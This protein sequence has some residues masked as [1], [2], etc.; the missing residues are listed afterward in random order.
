MLSW[1]TARE[2]CCLL[3]ISTLMSTTTPVI[4]THGENRQKI[5]GLNFSC[6]QLYLYGSFPLRKGKLDCCRQLIDINVDIQRTQLFSPAVYRLNINTGKSPTV[7]AIACSQEQLSDR[8]NYYQNQ[9]K[10]W[11]KVRFRNVWPTWRES[12]KQAKLRLHG[13]FACWQDY[14]LVVGW[15]LRDWH[16]IPS[17]WRTPFRKFTVICACLIYNNSRALCGLLQ[18]S[19][20]NDLVCGMHGS[21]TICCRLLIVVD[22]V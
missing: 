17:Q 20:T 10:K 22:Y 6:R 21:A 14:C 7:I 13:K 4:F 1:Y 3:W 12:V 8:K 5:S 9:L 15:D 16:L 18:L 11:P 19:R 2:K